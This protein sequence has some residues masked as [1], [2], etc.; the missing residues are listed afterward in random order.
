M[1]A[2][3]SSS[4]RIFTKAIAG[5]VLAS[6]CNVS[7]TCTLIGCAPPLQINFSPAQGWPA[8]TYEVAV[9]ADGASKRCTVVLPLSCDAPSQCE[10][11]GDWS[12]TSAG[13][14]LP[15]DQHAI[16]GVVFAGNPASVEVTVTSEL[17]QIGTLALTPSYVTTRPNGGDCEPVCRTAPTA[18]LAIDLIP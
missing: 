4:L 6:S 7:E 15:A 3:A 10:G 13:C 5:L 2:F 18:E 9:T 14:A 8:G 12:A 17:G 11:T 16:A 1:S